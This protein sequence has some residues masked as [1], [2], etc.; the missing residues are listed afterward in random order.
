MLWFESQFPRY[1]K[2]FVSGIIHLSFGQTRLLKYI[3]HNEHFETHFYHDFIGR[4]HCS[5]PCDICKQADR[6]PNVRVEKALENF[7]GS[8]SFDF[9]TQN[10]DFKSSPFLSKTVVDGLLC[11]KFSTECTLPIVHRPHFYSFTHCMMLNYA[12]Y[13]N[14]LPAEKSLYHRCHSF[15]NEL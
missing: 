13:T 14:L 5:K 6:E 12:Y 1:N 8:F 2:S 9:S 4:A 10:S 3:R 11:H 15:N 7:N